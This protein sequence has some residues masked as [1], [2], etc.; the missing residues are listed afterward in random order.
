MKRA[1]SDMRL[2]TFKKVVEEGLDGIL[3]INIEL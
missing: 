3:H 2:S 1:I